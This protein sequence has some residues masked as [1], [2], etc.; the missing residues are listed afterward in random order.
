MPAPTR[1]LANHPDLDQIRRQAKELLRAFSAREADAVAEVT[2]HYRA[3]SPQTFALHDAQLVIA[4]SYGFDSWPKLKA[5]VEGATIHR[6]VEAIA[7][8]DASAVRAMLALR[9][10]LALV[11][12]AESDEHQALHHAVLQRQPEIVR[13][14][15]QHGADPHKGIWPHRDATSPMTLA[16]D[17]GLTEIVAIMHGAPRAAAHDT[18]DPRVPA[19]VAAARRAIARGDASS[20]RAQHAEGRLPHDVGLVTCAVQSGRLEML[21]LLLE[22][23]LDPDE[24]GRLRGLEETVT[25]WGGP[26]RECAIEGN[27]AMAELLLTHGATPNTNVYAAS[28]AMFEVLARRNSAM[29]ALLERHGGIVNAT[30][31]GYLG[32]FDRARQ[33]LDA[34]LTNATA[35]ALLDAAAD[36]GY[37]DIVRMAL[38]RIDWP[39]GDGR[40]HWML[41]RP[42]GGR[43][44]SER[45]R[46]VACFR[47][48]VDRSGANA[49]DRFGRTILHDVAGAW[50]RSAPMGPADRIA[51]A[52][53]LLDRGAR[54]DARDDLLRSTPLGWACRYGRVEL[55]RLLIDRGA[56]PV[57]PDAEAWATPRA[58]AERMR[59]REVV[60]LLRSASVSRP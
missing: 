26:I 55:V 11:D 50:P 2:A 21:S 58:W 28:S 52:T 4:R 32:L 49:A 42:L 41:M 37:L 45:E 5:Y 9:P 12:V 60:Q 57:E 18:D 15:V 27:L 51:L 6:L 25:S 43:A 10:E 34:D 13:L 24:R 54:L 33:L 3:A 16:T 38:D 1:T 59:H 14:L 7:A 30:T 40:W 44:D 19:G 53:V 56:D 22:L 31:A 39:V 35:E 46:F 48:I 17:R 20:I 23:G 8:H 36:G 29:I 47:A